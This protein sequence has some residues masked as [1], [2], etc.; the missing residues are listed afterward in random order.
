[1]VKVRIVIN[2]ETANER[3]LLDAIITLMETENFEI[4]SEV[5]SGEEE[6]D[7]REEQ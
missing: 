4:D 2:C 6:E 7:G 1:M 5:V 3:K